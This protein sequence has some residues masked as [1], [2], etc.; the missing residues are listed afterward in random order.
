MEQVARTETWTRSGHSW[1]AV[2]FSIVGVILAVRAWSKSEV[3][4]GFALYVVEE[5]IAGRGSRASSPI[6]HR[7]SAGRVNSRN[8]KT[9]DQ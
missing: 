4:P 5:A 7:S 6:T 1:W 9:P 2:L 3:G 8:G